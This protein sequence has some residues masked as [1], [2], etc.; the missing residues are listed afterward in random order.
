[1]GTYNRCF[2]HVVNI[3]CQRV[4]KELEENPETPVL[5]TSTSITSSQELC[6]YANALSTKPITKCR[7]LVGA[8]RASGSRRRDLQEAIKSGN[9]K[10]DWMDSNGHA[11]ILREVQ[12]L[13]DCE[14]RWSS[15]FFMLERVLE[16][17]PVS[18]FHILCIQNIYL[19]EKGN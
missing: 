3:G 14:T 1:M 17:Y 19:C 9:L 13:R 18:Y 8:C 4:V 11:I 7:G 6:D 12:L 2:P 15:T 10:K 16:L 5:E